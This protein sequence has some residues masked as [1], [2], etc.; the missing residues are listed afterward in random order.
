MID[1]QVLASIMLNPYD[2]K[3]GCHS[4]GCNQ[5]GKRWFLCSY[6]E[7]YGDGLDAAQEALKNG[8]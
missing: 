6:H 8:N 3:R 1:K 4:C 7:G 2:D 5:R